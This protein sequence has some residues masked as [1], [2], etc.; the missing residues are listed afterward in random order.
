MTSLHTD[1]VPRVNSLS[2]A[3]FE[4]DFLAPLRPVVFRRLASAWP[5][6]NKW[7]PQF[8]IDNFGERKVRVYDASFAR[9]GQHYMSNIEVLPLREFLHAILD[10]SRDLR[11]FLYNI[12]RELPALLRDIRYPD[13]ADHFSRRFVF[14][15]FGSRG[16]V[17]PVH[18]DIDLSHVFYTSVLGRRR[19][20]LFPQTQSAYLYRHPL[21]VRSYVDVE[22]PDFS[23]FP[24]LADASGYAVTV[25]PGETLFMPSGYWHQV[26]YE[27]AG[28]GVSLRLPSEHFARRLQGFYNLTVVSPVDR[29]LNKLSSR[30]WFQ[31]K[32]R[33][34]DSRAARLGR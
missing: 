9:P 23:R 20:T 29:L 12:A 6:L 27:D 33:A 5:A 28:Y 8:F 17:T 3:A 13:L 32:E 26:S 1:P 11:M 31:F 7:T 34:A 15:F 19:I 10:T 24:A 2:K 4:R 18:Y 21:T 30:S 16:A 22:R 14:M 25:H